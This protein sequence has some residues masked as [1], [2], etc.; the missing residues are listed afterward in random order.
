MPRAIVLAA[1]FLL[2]LGYLRLCAYSL[3]RFEIQTFADISARFREVEASD[4]RGT[5]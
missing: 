3:Y 5:V 1:L 2:F 4:V